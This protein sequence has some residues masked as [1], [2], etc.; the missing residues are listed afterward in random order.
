MNVRGG[1]AVLGACVLAVLMS[2]CGATAPQMSDVDPVEVATETLEEK[3]QRIAAEM[4]PVFADRATWDAGRAV[5]KSYCDLAR[6][7]DHTTALETLV[8]QGMAEDVSADRV[9]ILIGIALELDCPD[10][11]DGAVLEY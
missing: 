3:A 10:L 9:G 2:G 1:V 6:A 8:L 5:S 11:A 7:T 4:D